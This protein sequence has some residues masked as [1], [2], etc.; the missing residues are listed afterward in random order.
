MHELSIVTSIIG[1]VRENM[2]LHGVGRL[3]KIKIQVGE[4][5]AVE[6]EALRFCFGICAEGT[7]MEGAILDIEE[8]PV[9]GQCVHCKK[10]FTL[11]RYSDSRCPE[12]GGEAG[13]YVSGT[14]LDIISMEVE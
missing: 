9:I 10:E 11:D 6:P 1:I 13:N 4:M 2:A 3:K 12:C 5:T 7:D 14:E 8:V